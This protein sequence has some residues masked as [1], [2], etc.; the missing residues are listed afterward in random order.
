M[1]LRGGIARVAKLFQL[2]RRLFSGLLGPGRLC[3]L[4]ESTA[5]CVSENPT[6]A[7]GQWAAFEVALDEAHSTEHGSVVDIPRQPRA[8][9]TRVNGKVAP[10]RLAPS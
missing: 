6:T 9:G 1:F 3:R 4:S 7:E 10:I 5:R 8:L 2:T